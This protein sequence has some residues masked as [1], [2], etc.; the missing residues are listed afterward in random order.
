MLESPKT[1]WWSHINK[2]FTQPHTLYYKGF[3]CHC[4]RHFIIL[5]SIYAF[6]WNCE[7]HSK[8]KTFQQTHKMADE[9]HFS[10]FES[11]IKY[12]S[13]CLFP[14]HTAAHPKLH[15][16]N[17]T[18]FREILENKNTAKLQHSLGLQFGCFDWLFGFVNSMDKS[19]FTNNKLFF[20]VCLLPIEIIYQMQ[21][22]E[23]DSSTN[24]HGVSIG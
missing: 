19:C 15:C 16:L 14:L 8:S 9:I 11:W 20:C 2:C 5:I 18:K 24:G 21:F 10:F 22:I 13:V 4:V 1:I 6:S 12:I 3:R 7:L 17:T 23:V